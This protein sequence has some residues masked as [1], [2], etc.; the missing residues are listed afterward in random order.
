[1]MRPIVTLLIAIALAGPGHAEDFQIAALF[2]DAGVEGI[3]VIATLDG[4]H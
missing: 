1:M 3:M 2:S 4:R